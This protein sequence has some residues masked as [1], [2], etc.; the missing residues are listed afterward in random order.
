[1]IIK[2]ACSFADLPCS[3]EPLP[4]ALYFI[5]TYRFKVVA[6]VQ[7]EFKLNFKKFQGKKTFLF[8]TL[9]RLSCV[10]TLGRLV[11]LSK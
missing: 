1:M 7:I 8:G 5:K 6:E 2:I 3:I 11:K 9:D 10:G 4:H